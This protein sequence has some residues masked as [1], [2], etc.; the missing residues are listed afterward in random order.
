MT[1]HAV[2]GVPWLVVLL[3]VAPVP[4]LLRAVEEWPYTVWPLQG[5]AVGLVAAAAVWCFDETAAAVV[6]TL[7]R[8]LAWRTAS[9]LLGV[10]VVLA[11]W[12]LSVAW[13]STAYFGR[14]GHVAWQGVAAI[15]AGAAY[16]TW[17]RSTGTAT[18][19]LGVATGLVC[20]ASFLALARP[21]D[22]QLPVFPYLDSGP[23]AAS[24]VLWA[25]IGLAALLGLAIV[26]AEPAT[27][28]DRRP[29]GFG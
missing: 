8:S 4:A 1:L 28:P 14:A 2:R 11:V 9:R 23:W 18:P 15:A 16:V 6:D 10:A 19:A 12:L 7:P 3:V 29:G 24:A 17:R 26:L 22:D 25:V 5:V 13:T 27:G 20:G 21:L